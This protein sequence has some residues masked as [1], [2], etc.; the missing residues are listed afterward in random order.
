MPITKDIVNQHLKC[1]AEKNVDGVLADYSSD[2]VLFV[3]G[4]PLRRTAAIKAFFEALVSEFSKPGAT[5]SME[6]QH[7]DGDGSGANLS[8]CASRVR[9]DCRS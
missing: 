3:P 2:A 7:A 8:E 5:F 6:Q 1:F 4:G 9:G